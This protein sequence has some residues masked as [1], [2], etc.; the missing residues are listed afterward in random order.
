MLSGYYKLV[1]R[2]SLAGKSGTLNGYTFIGGECDL[3]LLGEREYIDLRGVSLYFERS[4]QAEM[5]R[6]NEPEPVNLGP[7]A[8]RQEK[9]EE[10]IET[11]GIKSRLEQ[12]A[13]AIHALDPRNDDHWTQSGLPRVDAIEELLDDPSITRGEINEAA[14]GY[15]RPRR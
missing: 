10:P 7:L 14:P 13:D 3:G 9:P 1:L 2:G 15:E 4:Y 8:Q 12:I 5:V 6:Y 11:Y